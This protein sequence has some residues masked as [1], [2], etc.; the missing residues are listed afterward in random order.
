MALI[1]AQWIVTKDPNN[2]WYTFK[3][4]R[5][6]DRFL[7]PAP[8][9][10]P[11]ENAVLRGRATAEAAR[12]TIRKVPGTKLYKYESSLTIYAIVPNTDARIFYDSLAGNTHRAPGLSVNLDDVAA[13]A[14]VAVNLSVR[15]G[16]QTQ[17]WAFV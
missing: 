9:A 17:T 4:S 8:G 1:H 11:T 2:D 3:N 15:T 7:A 6:E 13:V 10:A 12:F 5:V 14:P 16:A